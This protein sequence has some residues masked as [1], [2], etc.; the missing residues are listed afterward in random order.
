MINGAPAYRKLL[1]AVGVAEVVWWIVTG[2]VYG[3]LSSSAQLSMQLLHP[4][5]TWLWISIPLLLGFSWYHWHWKSNLYEAYQGKGKTRMLW[6]TFSP[7]KAFIHYF[8]LRSV[9]FFAVLGLAQPVMGSKKVKGSKRVLDLVICLDISNS[10]NT[11]D[12]SNDFSRL[13]AAKNAISELLKQLKGERIGVVVFANEAYTQLPLTMDYGAAKLFIPDIET[14]M[15]SDQGTNI[16]SALEV[17]QEQFKDQ[18][19]GKAMLVITDGE[20]HEQLWQ[21]QVKLLNDKKVVLAY[22][23]LGSDAGGLIPNDPDDPSQGYKR[24]NGKAVVSHLD[25]NALAA[26]AAATSSQYLTTSKAFPDVVP[27]AMNFANA[28]NKTMKSL[29]FTVDKNYFQIP[30]LL[31]LFCF[32]AYLFLPLFV[33]RKA[34]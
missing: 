29:E 31:A 2:F 26:M 9:L 24:E 25:K 23:G 22:L 21:E 6:V 34:T 10:M 11:R 1:L 19:S 17:A 32:V 28:K 16:G 14:S 3:L 13:D 18:E 4:A 33:N 5:Y 20:D 15:I 12:M 27:L 30:V 8:L 7:L